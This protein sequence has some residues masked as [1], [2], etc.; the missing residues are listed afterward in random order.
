MA[1]RDGGGGWRESTKIFYGWWVVA[2]CFVSMAM[3]GGI[4]N[5]SFPIFLK[6]LTEE[7]G[8]SRAQ[9]SG[10]ISAFMLAIA[11]TAPLVGRIVGLYGARAV[12]GPAALVVGL[13]LML[14]ARLT[15]L[16]QLYALRLCVGVAFTALAHIPVNVTLSRWFVRKRGRAMGIAMIGSSV[17]GLVLTPLVAFSVDSLGWRPT[18]VVLGGVMWVVLAPVLFWLMRNKPANLGLLPDGDRRGAQ[19]TGTTV[20]A[21]DEGM[22]AGEAVRSGRFWALVGVYLLAYTCV[23]SA[24]VHQYPYFTDQGFPAGHAALLVSTLLSFAVLSGVSFGWASD[25]YDVL[26]LSAVCYAFGATGAAL[27]LWAGSVLSV[28][29]YLVCF[30]LLFGGTTPLTALVIGRIFG[31]NAYGVI[32]GFYQTVICLSGFIGPISMGYIYDVT[33]S[34]RVG[35]AGVCIGLLCASGL[36]LLLRS[37]IS[38]TAHSVF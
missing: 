33:G 34:Y 30:G 37:K 23:F 35:F 20:V 3:A 8:W 38:R 31:M 19:M 32:Y 7:F 21:T 6:P 13:C 10:G 14:L 24:M 22:S 5:L 16:W 27:L 1:D 36:M 26:R 28:P 9:V 29:G 17:G 11:V 2:A 25:R 15:T 12:M 4:G 18:L